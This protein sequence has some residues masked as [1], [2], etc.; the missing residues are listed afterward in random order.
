MGKQATRNRRELSPFIKGE[1]WTIPSASVS[2]CCFLTPQVSP[3]KQFEIAQE[4]LSIATE[5]DTNGGDHHTTLQALERALLKLSISETPAADLA[6]VRFRYA[7]VLLE[8]GETL[9]V[10]VRKWSW[11]C[12]ALCRQVLEPSPAGSPKASLERVLLAIKALIALGNLSL[13]QKKTYRYI[14][15]NSKT[16]ALL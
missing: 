6:P 14:V 16:S 13:Q 1:H 9:N 2:V 15:L 10:Q 12:A 11:L 3:H 8:I 5:L 4:S 7:Q